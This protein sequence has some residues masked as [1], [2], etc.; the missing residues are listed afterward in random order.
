MCFREAQITTE[1][2]DISNH[3]LIKEAESQIEQSTSCLFC[4]R[5]LPTWCLEQDRKVCQLLTWIRNAT[6]LFAHFEFSVFIPSSLLLLLTI[7][8][9][10]KFIL[11][12][13]SQ[14]AFQFWSISNLWIYVH[15]PEL[16][17]KSLLHLWNKFAKLNLAQ[18]HKRERDKSCT[19][20]FAMKTPPCVAKHMT[21]YDVNRDMK[22]H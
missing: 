2:L 13:T 16:S 3:S 17:R 6:H 9:V 11:L 12:N 14:S 7:K 10:P 21:C 19:C 22:N 8:R 4:R 1:N 20:V 5:T 18:E 15:F